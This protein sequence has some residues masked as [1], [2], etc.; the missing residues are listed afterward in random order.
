MCVRRGWTGGGGGGGG[1][2]GDQRQELKYRSEEAFKLN[3]C[4]RDTL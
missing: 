4:Y 2:G 1:R 3:F